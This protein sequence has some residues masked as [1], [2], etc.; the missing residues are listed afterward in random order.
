MAFKPA[1]CR[2]VQWSSIVHL[3]HS[4]RQSVTPHYNM[5][6][7]TTPTMPLL[8]TAR[9]TASSARGVL[10]PTTTN[11]NQRHRSTAKALDKALDMCYTTS[12][13]VK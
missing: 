6:H 11:S 2:A 12:V 9:H 5:L 3:R 1:L 13:G 8:R 4:T 10:Q 7:N